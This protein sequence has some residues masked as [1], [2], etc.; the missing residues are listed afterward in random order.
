MESPPVS[1]RSNI[2]SAT[3]AMS[4]A[5]AAVSTVVVNWSSSGLF[6]MSKVNVREL[7]G[8]LGMPP[9]LLPPPPLPSHPP[10]YLLKI[11]G[12]GAVSSAKVPAHVGDERVNKLF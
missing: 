12:V 1:K 7:K 4:A 6:S 9:S 3:A 11:A 8:E 10:R 2:A 5:V